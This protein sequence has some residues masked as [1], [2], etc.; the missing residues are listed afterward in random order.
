MQGQ[1][2]SP[3]EVE[4][5]QQQ[6]KSQGL[7]RGQVDGI[8]GPE[9]QTALMQFQRKEGLPQTAQLD[10][11]TLDRLNGGTAGSNANMG[12][13]MTNGSNAGARNMSASPSAGTQNPASQ[14]ST[15]PTGSTTR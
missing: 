12:S 6:L 9:T 10:Q 8:L 11:Q 14:N 2:A 7:Y 4:Q 3:A 13:S 15:G 1:P 5:A